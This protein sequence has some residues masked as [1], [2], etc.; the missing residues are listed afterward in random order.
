MYP[1]YHFVVKS[2]KLP[3]L[4]FDWL[5]VI[6]LNGNKSSRDDNGHALNNKSH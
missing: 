5:A 3:V 4:E 6:A 2:V 1:L